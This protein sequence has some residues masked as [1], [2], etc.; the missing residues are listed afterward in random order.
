MGYTSIQI[1]KHTRERLNELKLTSRQTYDEI[2]NV[3]MDLVPSEDDEGKY[4]SE[5]RYSLLKGM[6]DIRHG[7]TSSIKDVKERLGI[8]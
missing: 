2:L 5:F 8:E 4:S 6:L 7:K 3:L 1:D